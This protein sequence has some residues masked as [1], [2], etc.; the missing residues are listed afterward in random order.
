MSRKIGRAMSAATIPPRLRV[1][2]SIFQWHRRACDTRE[3]AGEG[4]FFSW[5]WWIMLLTWCFGLVLSRII[6][7]KGLCVGSSRYNNIIQTPT[8]GYLLKLKDIYFTALKPFSQC[9]LR[10]LIQIFKTKGKLSCCTIYS[11]LFVFLM[12]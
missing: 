4:K 12:E 2:N 11:E 1:L 9:L 5:E 6:P 3:N 8:L 10:T 7:Y